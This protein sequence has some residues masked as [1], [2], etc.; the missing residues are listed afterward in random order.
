MIRSKENFKKKWALLF[1]ISGIKVPTYLRPIG[2]MPEASKIS[3][4]VISKAA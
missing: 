3:A 1:D 2:S 4:Q